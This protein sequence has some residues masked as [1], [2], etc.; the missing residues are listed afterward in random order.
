MPIYEYRVNLRPFAISEHHEDWDSSRH[1]DVPLGTQRN[2][3][4]ARGSYTLVIAED[5]PNSFLEGVLDKNPIASSILELRSLSSSRTSREE[6]E[7]Q[8]ELVWNRN[9]KS[10]NYIRWDGYETVSR[11]RITE[12]DILSDLETLELD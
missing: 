3:E 7:H 5:L 12:E 2:A 1:S 9:T 11:R 8:V 6:R 10:F 4:E